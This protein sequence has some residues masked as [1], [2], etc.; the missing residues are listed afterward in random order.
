MP[1]ASFNFRIEQ[2][3][4]FQVVFRYL[5]ENQNAVNLKNMYVLLRMQDNTGMQYIFDRTKA[6]GA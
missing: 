6:T 1:A 4:D 3:S 5:D 2:G